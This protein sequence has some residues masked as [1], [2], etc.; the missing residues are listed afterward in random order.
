MAYTDEELQDMNFEE[1]LYNDNRSFIRIYWSFLIEGHVIINNFF[2]DSYLDLR[3]VKIS[4]LFFSVMINFFLNAFFYTDEYI[5][6][7]YH[8]DGVLNFSCCLIIF[9]I[10]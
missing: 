9:S 8:N 1:A 2:S 10:N 6:E 4:F 5:S 3:T 7:T